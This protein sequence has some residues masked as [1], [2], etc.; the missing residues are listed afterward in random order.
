MYSFLLVF[1]INNNIINVK[2]LDFCIILGERNATYCM[3]DHTSH[4]S[5]CNRP[6][7]VAFYQHLSL[8]NNKK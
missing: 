2:Y 1:K 8:N 5:G 6:T 4:K 7:K 3:S